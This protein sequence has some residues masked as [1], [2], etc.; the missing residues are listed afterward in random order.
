MKKYF[1]N[2]L[3]VFSTIVLFAQEVGNIE[4]YSIKDGLSQTT[5]TCIYQSKNGLLWI[6]TQDGIN[7]YDGYNFIKFRRDPFD[8]NSLSDNY[9][10][11]LSE[12]DNGNLLVATRHGLTIFDLSKNKFQRIRLASLKNGSLED[13]SVLQ[14]LYLHSSIW[15]LTANALFEYT[16][17]KQLKRY[18]FFVDTNTSLYTYN[19]LD[20]IADR[21]G[22][23]WFA[24]KDGVNTFFIKNKQFYRIYQNPTTQISNNRI[25]SLKQDMQGNMWIGTFNG[26]NK[27]NYYS[28]SIS[29]YYYYQ[30]K[31]FL[32][33]NTINAIEID[34]TGTKWIGTKNGLKTFDGK[35]IVDFSN[36]SINEI[37]IQ[38]NALQID[39]SNILW[40]GTV[41]SG[42][43]KISLN[44]LTFDRFTDF[45]FSD[46]SVFAIYSDSLG[47]IWIG[48]LGVLVIDRD[49]KLALHYDNLVFSDTIQESTVY[50]F[51]DAEENVWAGTDNGI[52]I[53]NKKTF[54]VTD[55]FSYFGL[56]P[57][58]ILLNSRIY[59]II[60][61]NNGIFWFSTINGLIKFDGRKFEHFS[62]SANNP[63][64]I[65]SNIVTRTIDD[66]DKL[67]I[68]TYNGLNCFDKKTKKFKHWTTDNGL[69]SNFILDLYKECDTC[70]WIA[71]TEGLAK[72]NLKTERFFSFTARN[73]GF[74]N[75]FF[76]NIIPDDDYLWLSSNYGVVKF[77]KLDKTFTTYT[78]K[79]GLPFFECNIGAAYKDSNYLYFGGINGIGWINLQNNKNQKTPPNVVITKIEILNSIDK[80]ATIYFPAR[81]TVLR[82]KY[83]DMLNI[84]FTLPDFNYPH[85]NKYFFKIPEISDKWSLPQKNNNLTLTGLSPGTYTLYI[86]GANSADITC[87]E[88]THITFEIIPPFWKSIFA[89]FIYAILGILFLGVIFY[90][91]Y[92]NIKAENAILQEKNV[93]Y[94]QIEEQKRL[95]EVKNKNITDSITYAQKIIEAIL[96]PI[97]S[98]KVF[99]PESFILFKPKDIVSGDFYWFTEKNDHIYIAAVDCT[100]HGIPGAF[101]SIIGMNLLNTLVA[102]GIT[103]PGVIL[104]MMNKEVI[105]TLKKKFDATHLKD[106]MDMALCIIDNTRNTLKFAGAY[107]PAYVIRDNNII[108]LKG[109]R[110]SVGND[111][112]ADAFTTFN[113]KIR[114]DDMVYLFSDGYTDQF[115]GP[116]RKKFK[117][118]RFRFTLL[119]IH[120]LPLEK[121]KEKLEETYEKWKGNNEQVDDVLII[122]F[123]LNIFRK[124]S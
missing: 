123:R 89:Y 69:P 18:N 3:F 28:H 77:N 62:F 50:C 5:V 37:N 38:I 81:D 85:N 34:K 49:T 9:I 45:P 122:G 47:R 121:Q 104:N 41:G 109:D 90:S 16:K 112:D 92:K 23:I 106:G 17:E 88:P 35:Q 120:K 14:V 19:T 7:L 48:A 79:D 96:P 119:S 74:I 94:K 68:A 51:F 4:N 44:K 33:E 86:K 12:D 71:T 97:S 108:Q 60:K 102:E 113:M 91:V 67:W 63:D 46:K 6:G 114:N 84:Y 64:A 29:S 30:N 117:F 124:N 54:E 39:K 15:M 13:N 61:D 55:I 58:K 27:Y 20:M 115:G 42:L 53:I 116:E 31:D 24:T 73:T 80:K 8:T 56:Q 40:C 72:F 110:K 21:N 10:N 52:F 59:K 36:Q 100:G 82:F 11:D 95:L 99:L 1:L 101:M 111:F 26:L 22:N 66:N 103:D 57:N 105:L 98:L 2:I 93:A 25:R 87:A 32:R 76:Y 75:D 107:N 118:R 70:I 65:S 78:I 43:Y 83:N